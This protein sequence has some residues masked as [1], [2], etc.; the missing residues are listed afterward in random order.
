MNIKRYYIIFY[1]LVTGS[2]SNSQNL[3]PNPGFD[4]LTD[5]PDDH[6]QIELAFP[7]ISSGVS[8]DLY[9]RCSTSDRIKVPHAGLKYDSYQEPISGEGY[10]GIF[11][12]SLD[13]SPNELLGVPLT[14]P[15]KKTIYIILG[16]LYLQ[17]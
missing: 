12:Y 7:W 6:G 3:I 15:L 5:C 13:P 1:L 8:P 17:T 10:A 16:F 11:A 2:L 9:N 4:I 14:N